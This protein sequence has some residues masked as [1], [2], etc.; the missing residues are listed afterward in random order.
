MREYLEIWKVWTNRKG[1][2]PNEL[3]RPTTDKAASFL[4]NCFK[5]M[6]LQCAI[7]KT[8]Q[9]FQSSNGWKILSMSLRW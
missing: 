4:K 6:C 3:Y 8:Q 2:I 9:A 7:L 5:G 1:N